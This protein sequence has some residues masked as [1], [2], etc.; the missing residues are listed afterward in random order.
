MGGEIGFIL[1]FKEV[2]GRGLVIYL[3]FIYFLTFVSRPSP[4]LICYGEGLCS[5][6]NQQGVSGGLFI[7]RRE[8]GSITGLREYRLGFAFGG[9]VLVGWL[10][11]MGGI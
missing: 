10:F 2:G 9:R 4:S 8:G 5:L 7:G 3:L 11:G 6:G 1:A